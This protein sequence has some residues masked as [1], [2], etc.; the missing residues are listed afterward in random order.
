MNPDIAEAVGLNISWGVLVTQVASGGPADEA[1]L[2]GGSAYKTILGQTVRVGGDLIIAIDGYRVF[3]ADDL[4]LYIERSEQP[5]D[6]VVLTFLRSGE[7][8]S[9]TVT[10][11]ERP[12][13]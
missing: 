4:Y 11:G 3:R 9:L 2:R 5:G 1:G 6:R 7:K 8:M 13:V 10:L 12:P